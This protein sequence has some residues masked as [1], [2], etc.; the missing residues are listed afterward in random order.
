VSFKSAQIGSLLS[1]FQ[2]PK[3]L[4]QEKSILKVAVLSE[5]YFPKQKLSVRFNQ[6]VLQH[7]ELE[8]L[9]EGVDR[10]SRS[11]SQG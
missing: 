7:M 11:I 4:K 6:T 10:V 9:S 3:P 2:T 5:P 8:D 1:S